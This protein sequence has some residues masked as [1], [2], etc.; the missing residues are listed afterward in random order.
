MTDYTTVKSLAMMVINNL[1]VLIGT[2][3][4]QALDSFVVEAVAIPSTIQPAEH[5]KFQN[6]H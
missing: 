5:H 1:G 3:K 6:Y 2:R 4:I